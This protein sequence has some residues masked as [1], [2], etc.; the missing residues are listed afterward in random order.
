MA[1]FSWVDYLIF[2]VMLVVS[3]GVGLYHAFAKGGQKTTSKYL[4]GDRELGLIPVTL[5]LAVTLVSAITL[6]GTPAEIYS[7]GVQ[8]I[9]FPIGV[10]L[11]TLLSAMIFA[12]LYFPLMVTSVNEVG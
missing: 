2:V 3:A 10:N 6:Q 12:P 4:M 1:Y 8:F 5:S 11:G 7:Y 9:L